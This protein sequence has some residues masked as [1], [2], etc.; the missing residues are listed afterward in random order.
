MKRITITMVAT[1]AIVVA[2]CTASAPMG[3]D[4]RNTGEF[5]ATGAGIFAAGVVQ[6]FSSCNEF[7]DYA[8]EHAIERV[9]P[10]GLDGYGFSKQYAIDELVFSE[11]SAS[12][13]GGADST[14]RT[15]AAPS[16]EGVD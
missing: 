6:A 16:L 4:T 3:T 8:K 9:G 5:G 12:L 2:A 13:D 1:F 14:T 15:T 10:Y 11:A 7:L